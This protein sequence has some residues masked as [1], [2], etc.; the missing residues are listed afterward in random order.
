MGALLTMVLMA[1]PTTPVGSPTP[2]PSA[3]NSPEEPSV[4]FQ[5]AAEAEI[6]E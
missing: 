5:Y 2:E 3:S 1:V 6:A 4:T